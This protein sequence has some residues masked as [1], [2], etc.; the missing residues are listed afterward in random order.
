MKGKSDYRGDA[1]A[2][3]KVSAET[4]RTAWRKKVDELS[5]KAGTAGRDLL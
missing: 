4:E 2:R 1:L 3:A 5:S